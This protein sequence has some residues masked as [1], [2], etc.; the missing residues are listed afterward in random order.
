[1]LEERAGGEGVYLR[2][3]GEP[4]TVKRLREQLGAA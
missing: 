4:E 1:V 3:R 2:V